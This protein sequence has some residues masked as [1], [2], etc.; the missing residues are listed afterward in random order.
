M[1]VIH[2]GPGELGMK[3]VTQMDRL[4][5]EK[6]GDEGLANAARN[7]AMMNRGKSIAELRRA[8]VG[9]GDSAIVIAAGPSI[10]RRN[11]IE[12]IKATSYKGALIATD[13][14]MYYCLR[15]GVVPDIVVSV[16]PQ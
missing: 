14:A 7:Q 9:E 12:Q 2:E 3:F 15:N 1:P 11:P 13:S 10:T 8:P 5:L 6:I 16:D 4:T